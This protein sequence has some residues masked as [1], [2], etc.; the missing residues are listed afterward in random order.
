MKTIGS[1]ACAL[2][3]ALA[4]GGLAHAQ[5]SPAEAPAPEVTPPPLESP[6]AA[7]AASEPAYEVYPFNFQVVPGL[8]LSGS[9][10]SRVEQHFALDLIGGKVARLDGLELAT[11]FAWESES[12]S[13]VQLSGLFGVVEGPVS[14]AQLSA[15]V[16]IATGPATGAQLATAVSVA[17]DVTGIQGAGGVNVSRALTGVQGAGGLNIASGDVLGMQAAGGVNIALTR[18]TGVQLA[19]GVNVTDGDVVG[20]QGAPLNVTTGRVR[21]V[22]LGV[23]NYAE[24]VDAPIGILSIVKNGQLHMDVWGSDAVP[25]AMALR[26]GGKYVYNLFALGTN[27]IGDQTKWMLGWGIGGHIP[28]AGETWFVDIDLL[29]WHINEGDQFT[30]E[31]NLL[32]QVRVTAGWRASERFALFGGVTANVLTSRV[33]DG[34]DWRLVDFSSSTHNGTDVR[35]WPGFLLG[36]R[37]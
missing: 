25:A 12:A 16:S 30:T 8:A 13:G 19:G 33:S 26:I 21:G 15:G 27:P 36:I 11:L 24:D 32:S 31:L 5:E 6:M 2:C 17:E 22:Q 3:I 23:I 34:S 9:D 7:A 18:V 29:T 28:V 10:G 20:L 14:G 1:T 35:G 4:L 37:I